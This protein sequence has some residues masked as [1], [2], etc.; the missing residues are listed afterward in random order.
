[1]PE[2]T[3]TALVEHFDALWSGNTLKRRPRHYTL[4]FHTKVQVWEISHSVTLQVPA[5]QRSILVSRRCQPWLAWKKKRGEK[6]EKKKRDIKNK[7]KKK[8]KNKEKEN[9]R[10]KGRRKEWERAGNLHI[11]LY[12]VLTPHTQEAHARIQSRKCFTSFPGLRCS[13]NTPSPQ[14]FRDIHP[15][16]WR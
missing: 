12:P 8:E 16:R 13:L 1:M 3:R 10:E 9:E 4:D 15:I 14:Q 2:N 5:I 6:K 11:K 7:K